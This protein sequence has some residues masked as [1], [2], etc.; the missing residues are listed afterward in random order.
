[1]SVIV[2]KKINHIFLEIK[3]N[4][5]IIIYKNFFK[6]NTCKKIIDICHENYSLKYN[7]KKSKNK[8]INFSSIDV[9][10][11]SV[12]TDRIFRTFVMSDY[13]I[14]KFPEI[15][16]LIT[17]QKKILKL[18]FKKKIYRKVQII[19]YPKGGGFF[20]KHHHP[21]YPTN[22]GII[23][24]LSEKFK[25]F[26]Q[27]VTNFVINKKNISLEKFNLEMGDLIL[28]R[29][30][31]PHYISPV[32]PGEDLTFNKKGRWTLVLPVYHEKF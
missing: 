3:K 24:T 16:N 13:F 28:F 23:I 18:K 1:M 29:F 21:R 12:K 2:L 32:D 14:S 22:Y 6:K 25:D 30:D 20:D 10:P 27:G 8:F 7:R 9:L 19:H 15:I 11:S 4:T 5:P 17:F 26:K 31:I